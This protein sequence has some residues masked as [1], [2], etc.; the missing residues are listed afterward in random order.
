MNCGSGAQNG[1]V[2]P[3]PNLRSFGLGRE[4]EQYMGER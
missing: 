2:L 4:N 3:G 1:E